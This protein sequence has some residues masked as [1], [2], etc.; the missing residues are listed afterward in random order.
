MAT[1]QTSLDDASNAADDVTD[2]ATD[3]A[4]EV[5]EAA[6][7]PEPPSFR[8]VGGGT[9]VMCP[10]CSRWSRKS[11]RCSYDD[12]GHDLAKEG[13]GVGTDPRRG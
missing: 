11:Y 5:D 9:P 8:T 12:C 1:T 13:G 4:S 3:E 7:E 10:A 2:T 6:F